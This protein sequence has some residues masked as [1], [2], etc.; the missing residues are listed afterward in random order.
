MIQSKLKR[1]SQLETLARK[2]DVVQK[3]RISFLTLAF[4]FFS[5]SSRDYA[6]M[7]NLDGQLN[8]DEY[9]PVFRL[10]MY[11]DGSKNKN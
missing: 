6:C 8:R 4:L 11:V 9:I 2:A 10:L 5:S 3:G 7:T 1:P